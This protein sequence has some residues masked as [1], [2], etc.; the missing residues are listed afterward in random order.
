MPETPE[1]IFGLKE[2]IGEEKFYQSM[3]IEYFEEIESESLQTKE[4]KIDI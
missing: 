3:S 4:K 1:E 2:I